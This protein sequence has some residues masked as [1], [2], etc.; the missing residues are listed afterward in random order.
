MHSVA[1]EV[2]YIELMMHNTFLNVFYLK[3]I[4]LQLNLSY[5]LNMSMFR[6]SQVILVTEVFILFT[7]GDLGKGEWK[8]CSRKQAKFC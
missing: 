4:Y 8:T 1:F 2:L 6:H 7:I 5:S 3:F